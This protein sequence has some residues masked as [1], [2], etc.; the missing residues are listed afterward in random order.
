[1]KNIG[2]PSS[3]KINNTIIKKTGLRRKSIIN[4]T[5]LS[6]IFIKLGI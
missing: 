6:N 3:K 5:I 1:V 4:A 2:D